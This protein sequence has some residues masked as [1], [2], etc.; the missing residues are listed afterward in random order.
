LTVLRVEYLSKIAPQGVHNGSLIGLLKADSEGVDTKEYL[1][2]LC[3]L[4]PEIHIL[5]AD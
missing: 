1:S 3:P 4:M 2:G 5:G